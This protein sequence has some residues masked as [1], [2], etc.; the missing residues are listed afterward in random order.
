MVGSFKLSGSEYDVNRGSGH[1]KGA[2]V[3]VG[4]ERV[5]QPIHHKQRHALAAFHRASMAKEVT[6]LYS[7]DIDEILA[8][9]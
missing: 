6:A 4:P 1:R 7:A 8:E 9:V 2:S 3:K 5:S